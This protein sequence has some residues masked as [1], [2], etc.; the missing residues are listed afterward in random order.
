[1]TSL[2]QALRSF[3]TGDLSREGLFFELEHILTDG[4]ADTVWLL[5]ALEQEHA[6]L[7][8]PE[9]IHSAV[10]DQ[11]ERAASL[12]QA[13]TAARAAASGSCT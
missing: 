7:P 5:D 2:A 9:E 4:R 12:P 8:L 3:R 6:K 10:R 11:I 13:A 1:M